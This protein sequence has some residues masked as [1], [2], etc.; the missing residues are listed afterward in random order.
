[1]QLGLDH[2]ISGERLVCEAPLPEVFEK[3]LTLLR[4]RAGSPDCAR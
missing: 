4:R 3:L 2:P 1:V